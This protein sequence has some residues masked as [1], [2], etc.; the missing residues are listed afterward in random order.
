M[1]D[2]L[3]YDRLAAQVNTK[4]RLTEM[5]EPIELEL[6]EATE[7][8]TTPQQEIFSL[9]FLGPKD[10]LLPQSIYELAH[11]Q[12]GT[13]ALFLVPIERTEKG[14]RYE[15]AFNRLINTAD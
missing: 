12:L 13:G 14:I 3:N 9:F 10:F 2:T 15:A 4:F 11:D 8:Q 1:L 7:P 6:V 5:T